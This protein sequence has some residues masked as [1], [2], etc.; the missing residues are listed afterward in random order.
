MTGAVSWSHEVVLDSEPI[1]ALKARNFV[2]THLIDHRLRYLLDPVRLVTSELAT[3]AILHAHTPFTLMLARV[4]DTVM[5]TVH[6]GSASPP[7]AGD[8][9][10]LNLGGRGLAI[11]D[12]LSNDW[13]VEVDEGGT[14][15]VWA[16]FAARRVPV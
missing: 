10:V 2:C 12:L 13:G 9:D 14:K 3:N 11:V 7:V 5:L 15:S 8:G 4:D 1:S 16:A 6:D